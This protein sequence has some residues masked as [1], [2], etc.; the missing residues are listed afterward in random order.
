M[1]LEDTLIAADGDALARTAAHL[2]HAWVSEAAAARGV[3]RVALSGGSTPRA[4]NRLLAAMDL[5]WTSTEWFWVDDRFVPPDNPRSNLGAARADLFDRLPSTP[6]A[7]HGMPFGQDPAACA[8]TYEKTLANAFGLPGPG[9]GPLPAFD[10]LLLGVGDDGHTAS[11]FPGDPY[12]DEATR[13]VIPVAA[14]EGREARLTL[15]RPVITAA[16]R[17][18]VLAQGPSKREPLR[19][20]RA[21]GPLREVPS[22]LVREVQG[23][24]LWLLDA[25]A[26]GA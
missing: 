18:V 11:L 15:S 22:R 3:A 8:E 25:S 19:L 17:V 21:P 5:P 24:L 14:A 13:W 12:I 20:A 16:R 1:P 4:M 2:V 7:V 26:A 9:A 10:L 23:E 6:R